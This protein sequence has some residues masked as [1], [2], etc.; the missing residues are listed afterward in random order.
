M[1]ATL[2]FGGVILLSSMKLGLEPPIRLEFSVYFVL[3]VE[4]LGSGPDSRPSC[5]NA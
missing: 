2:D 5:Y 4:G 1:A 3:K